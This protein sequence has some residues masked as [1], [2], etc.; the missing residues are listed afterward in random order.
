MVAESS[1]SAH[2]DLRLGFSGPGPVATIFF[3]STEN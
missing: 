2:I 1:H 3:Q